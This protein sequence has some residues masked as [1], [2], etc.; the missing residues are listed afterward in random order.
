MFTPST[1][2]RA[3]SNSASSAHSAE[4]NALLM[5]G[6]APHESVFISSMRSGR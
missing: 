5:P 6:A 3:I 2:T 1:P 4:T